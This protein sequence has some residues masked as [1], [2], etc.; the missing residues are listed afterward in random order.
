MHQKVSLHM[1]QKIVAGKQYYVA[2]EI[3]ANSNF[4]LMFP[5]RLWAVLRYFYETDFEKPGDC[6]Y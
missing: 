4:M 5:R 1:W 3:R 2:I 6:I